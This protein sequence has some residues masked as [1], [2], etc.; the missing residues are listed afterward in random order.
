MFGGIFILRYTPMTH[1]L[2][3]TF[4]YYLSSTGTVLFTNGVFIGKDSPE[5][6]T[7]SQLNDLTATWQVQGGGR[8]GMVLGE[9]ATE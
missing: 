6:A 2:G 9:D 7:N 1:E 5:T 4:H 8:M 3:D